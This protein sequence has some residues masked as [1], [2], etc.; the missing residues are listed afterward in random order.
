MSTRTRIAILL[1]LALGVGAASSALSIHSLWGLRGSI[2]E[3]TEHDLALTRSL[4]DVAAGH[5]EQAVQLERALRFG[6]AAAADPAA[7]ARYRAAVTAFDERASE[8]W[9][10]LRRGLELSEGA[11]AAEGRSVAALLAELDTR[12]NE[13][14]SAVRGVFA[15][16]DDGRFA[17][18]RRQAARVERH[19]EEFDGALREALLAVSRQSDVRTARIASDQ[20]DAIGLVAALTLG[21]LAL[22]M[23]LMARMF[24]LVRQLGT[25]RGLLPICSNCK[26]IRDDQG[27]W[28]GLEAYVEAHSEAEFTH[29]LCGGCVDDLKAAT[30][31]TRE[32]AREPA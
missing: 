20:R 15:A 7:H 12:H 23:L 5:L 22:G 4:S 11:P 21:A 26:K 2:R 32:P 29:G 17:D 10:A 6:G 16:F 18:A 1:V 14:A 8:M 24:Y 19:E 28:N 31:A 27:Y 25:L 30:L 3:I 13:Y 9:Y